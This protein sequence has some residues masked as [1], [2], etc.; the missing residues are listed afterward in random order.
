MTSDHRHAAIRANQN[1][2]N[3]K[4][5][6]TDFHMLYNIYT[7][8]QLSIAVHP[9]Q[10]REVARRVRLG[11]S[12]A[13]PFGCRCISIPTILRFH[14]PLVKPDV[15]ISRIRLSQ[16]TFTNRQPTGF[17]ESEPGDEPGPTHHVS[18]C[19]RQG[20][21]DAATSLMLLPIPDPFALKWSTRCSF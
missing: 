10:S 21:P 1:R 9:V 5:E 18:A 2:K 12:V 20:R 6:Q 13:D 17:G 19:G 8:L 16:E 7:L 14:L 11:L 3:Q 4:W 15:R